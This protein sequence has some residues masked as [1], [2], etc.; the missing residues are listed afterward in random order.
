[1]CAKVSTASKVKRMNSSKNKA[2]TH[3]LDKNYSLFRNEEGA[4]DLASIMV[5][6]LVIG[7][8]G[9]VI[10]ATIFAV[11]PWA[12]DSAAK[13]QLESIHTAENAYFGFSSTSLASLPAGAKPNSFATSSQLSAAS[14]LME[15]P[16][17]YC[18]ASSDGS[19]YD[20]YSLSDTGRVWA[21]N[22]KKVAPH[23]VSYTEINANL[24]PDLKIAAQAVDPS[25]TGNTNGSTIINPSTST[26]ISSPGMGD[27][28]TAATSG[29]ITGDG[30]GSYF[31]K[32]TAWLGAYGAPMSNTLPSPI[33]DLSGWSYNAT[34]RSVAMYFKTNGTFTGVGGSWIYLMNVD[35]SCYDTNTKT[36]TH[37][38]LAPANSLSGPYASNN[39]GPNTS[40]ISVNCG[41]GTPSTLIPSQVYL[42][43]ATDAEWANYS[44]GRLGYVYSMPNL[45]EGWVNSAVPQ[46]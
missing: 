26:D 43:T 39:P 2:Q 42:R 27:G 16:A 12:Q 3:L 4:I 15:T 9:G 41:A 17:R 29:T 13:H 23:V 18:A 28:T 30:S 25:S 32:N 6:V 8:V 11:I 7:L 22:D 5:G 44:L 19:S 35:I 24:C 34:S 36:Y 20:A 40:G 21:S 37:N 38:T 46:E 10:A 33:L 45:S 1:M 14:L 31:P